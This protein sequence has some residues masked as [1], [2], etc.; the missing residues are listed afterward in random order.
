MTSASHPFHFR[1]L[2]RHQAKWVAFY[3][4]PRRDQVVGVRQQLL[5]TLFAEKQIID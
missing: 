5:L 3:I 4:F 1:D 2:L